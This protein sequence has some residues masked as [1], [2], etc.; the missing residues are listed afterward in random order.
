[1]QKKL[2]AVSIDD[3]ATARRTL[4]R[5]LTKYCPLVEMVGEAEDII[6]GIKLIR[7]VQPQIVFLDI[8]IGS[9]SGFDLLDLL[10][11]INF[12]L[13]FATAYDQYAIKAFEYSAT[14]YL[15][16]P[17]H[18][19]KLRD[20]VK[21]CEEKIEEDSIASRAAL[22]QSNLATEPTKLALNNDKGYHFIELSD[23]TWLSSNHGV[24]TFYCA[25]GNKI[26]V[27][28]NIGEYDKLLP[29]SDF[30]RCHQSHIINL[31]W[32]HGYLHQEGGAIILKG[33]TKIPLARARREEFMERIK[34]FSIKA[35]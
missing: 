4:S 22:L 10:Q 23:L 9:H 35:E 30:F 31:H 24:T 21:K 18:P 3:E 16:K 1:M 12:H 14:H 7:K 33:G 25:N 29:R 13:V 32:V 6:S 2:T 27:A 8:Q 34:T 15:L 17:I 11:E 28:R 26:N 5:M 19:E 20:V